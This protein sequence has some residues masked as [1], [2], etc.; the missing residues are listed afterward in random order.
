VQ[1]RFAFDK[2]WTSVLKR[3]GR[4]DDI[5]PRILS[6]LDRLGAT[7]KMLRWLAGPGDGCLPERV[8]RYERLAAYLREVAAGRRPAGGF[9]AVAAAEPKVGVGARPTRSRKRAQRS[10]SGDRLLVEVETLREELRETRKK[11]RR[12]RV[13][14]ARIMAAAVED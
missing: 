1:Q 2:Y 11:E 6:E 14:L 4:L 3:I 13:A 12:R 5:D 8:A 10:A 7:L 9:P